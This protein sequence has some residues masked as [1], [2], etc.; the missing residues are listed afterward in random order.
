MD[1]RCIKHNNCEVIYGCEDCET[2]L[3]IQ[4][5]LNSYCELS[6]LHKNPHI[7]YFRQSKFIK[8]PPR[9]IRFKNYIK[10]F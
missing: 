8:V 2:Y 10:K 4:C 7:H 3:C 1:R 5:L 6:K 9:R